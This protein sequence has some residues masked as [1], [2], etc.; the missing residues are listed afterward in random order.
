MK[1]SLNANGSNNMPPYGIKIYLFTGEQ[2]ASRKN[3]CPVII[4]LMNIYPA[5]KVIFRV[6]F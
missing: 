2:Y 1:K 4:S 6:F 3:Y 5:E